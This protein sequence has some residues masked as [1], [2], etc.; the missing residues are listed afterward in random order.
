MSLKVL[1][2]DLERTLVSD[3]LRAEPR[4]GLLGFLSFCNEAFERVALFTTVEEADA[5]EVLEALER[6]GRLP[7][8]L[9]DRIEHVAWEGEYKDLRFIPDAAPDEVLLVDDD[10]GW[11][12]PGQRDRWLPI[13]PWD[14]GADDELARVRSALQGW[15]APPAD[16]S[17]A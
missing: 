12:H 3:A 4:P 13:A 6:G 5:R 8:G 9:H 2:L 17:D 11:V 15:L 14:G 7:P 16:R 10:G 1:A